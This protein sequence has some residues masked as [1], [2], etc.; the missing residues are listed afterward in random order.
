MRWLPGVTRYGVDVVGAESL[1]EVAGSGVQPG[2]RVWPLV[3]G[4]AH[5]PLVGLV[6]VGLQVAQHQLQAVPA[7]EAGQSG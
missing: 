5:H 2:E 6:V 7:I 1:K 4:G 3:G